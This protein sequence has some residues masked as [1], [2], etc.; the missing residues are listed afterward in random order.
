MPIEYLAGF[1][2]NQLTECTKGAVPRNQNSPQVAPHG[3]YAEQL[4]GSAFTAPR[5]HNWKSWQYRLRPSVSHFAAMTPYKHKTFSSTALNTAVTPPTQMRWDPLEKPSNPT[6]FI[7][8]LH[9]MTVNAAGS[10]HHYH[11]TA[12]ML[13]EF[14]YSADGDW[15]FIPVN[16]RLFIKTEF[17]NLEVAP[18]EIAVVQRG[19][20]FQVTCPDGEASGYVS[21]S[22]SPFELPDRGPIGANGMAEERHF[23]NP[24]ANFEDRSGDFTLITQFQGR[25]WSCPIKHSPLDVVGWHGNYAPYKYDLNLF[26]PVWSVGWD[27]SDPS[28]FTVLTAKSPIPG[29][30]N[31]DFVVFPARWMVVD[32]TFRPPY[33]HRNMMSEYMG[34]IHGEYDAKQEGFAPGSASLHNCMSPHGPDKATFDQA[35]TETLAPQKYDSTFTFMLE[36]RFI[37]DATEFAL[38]S[39]LNQ[40][41]YLSCWNG[42]ES[43][44]DL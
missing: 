36:S 25:L 38:K 41:D 29:T 3:L 8:S 20:R 37:W 13:D 39:P 32:H 9:T 19:I 30:A 31:I 15:L 11:A 12:D 43:L 16:G 23:L 2:N 26:N 6:H 10:I 14:F 21:E 44:Y 4:S 34:L 33:Y 28:I 18:Q 1:Y 22:T 40:A 42:L 7:D 5:T 35:S 17:G 24:V 27:H